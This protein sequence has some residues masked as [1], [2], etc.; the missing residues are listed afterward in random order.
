MEQISTRTHSLKWLG[1]T[2]DSLTGMVHHAATKPLKP[3]AQNLIEQ[4]LARNPGTN[5]NFL[6]QFDETTLR[7]YLLRLEAL[8]QPR[9]PETRMQRPGNTPAIMQ[10]RRIA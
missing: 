10:E 2:F 4:I 5:V 6:T 9:G 1:K 7:Q 8:A 3:T